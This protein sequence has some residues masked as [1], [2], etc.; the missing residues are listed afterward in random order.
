MKIKYK[1][2][3]SVVTQSLAIVLFLS[4][5][6]N[7]IATNEA[8]IALEKVAKNQLISLRETT[9]VNIESYFNTIRNQVITFSN[10]R[11]IIDA[12]AQFKSAYPRYQDQVDRSGLENARNKLS[13]YYQK[14]FNREFQNQNNEKSPT[15]NEWLTQL[16]D[17]SILLQ[18]AFISSN[19][20]KLGEKDKLAQ[21]GGNSDYG[22]LHEKY[23]QHIRDFQVRFGFYDI[24]LVEPDSGHIVYSV[25]KE[26]DFAT[27]LQTGAFAKTGIG[28]AFQKANLLKDAADTAITDFAPY[29]PS[30]M[31]AASFIASP[32]YDQGHK[33]GI[34][35]FQMPIDRISSVMTHNNQWQEAGLG[36]SGET[37]LVGADR[38]ARTI[39]R[40]LIED[41][42]N[43]FTALQS[44]GVSKLSLN[45][46]RAKNSNI[47]IQR[48]DTFGV[49]EALSGRRGFKVFPDYRNIP[50]LSAYAPVN[51][52]GLN[53]VI[54]AE[55]DEVEAYQSITKLSTAITS[56]SLLVGILALLLGSLVSW[57]LANYIG[58]L[59]SRMSDAMKELAVGDGDLTQRLD[60]STGDELSEI[61]GWFNQFV[62]KLQQMIAKLSQVTV[63][64]NE[65]SKE[66]S[67]NATESL[68]SVSGQQ[69]ETEQLATAMN[70]MQATL[71]E[72]S[73][74]VVAAAMA[75]K[76]ITEE[77]SAAKLATQENLQ[78]STNLAN[79]ISETSEVI[80]KLEQDSDA[81]GSVLDVIKQIADQTNLLALN[82]AIEAARAGEQGRGFAVVADEVRTLASRTQ[83]STQEI[84]LMIESLQ[85]AAKNS[86]HSMLKSTDQAHESEELSNKI[87]EILN[88]ID[89]SISK[90]ND[91]T[92]QI[93]TASE[94]QA[95]VAE[96]INRNVNQI[97]DLS[98]HSVEK[99]HETSETAAQ[100]N[101]LSTQI[102]ELVN[103][104]K[105]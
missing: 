23:H 18:D 65:F 52:H 85:L 91:M 30:Y 27:S 99:I 10:D 19:S 70:E 64:L 43:Y 56:S 28:E 50:V 58:K 75:T 8:Q 17:N 29:P 89:H 101:S 21:V 93:A 13:N 102:T 2:I 16:D 92:T 69:S 83:S 33:V 45:N 20:H 80:T 72:V 25:F 57:L 55:I 71:N 68:Q 94:E 84:Q 96:D 78:A 15:S 49:S 41:P 76:D 105:I 46:I 90:I 95:T 48:I 12:M 26:L 39:S 9:R 3:L 66:Q 1:L 51:I 35:I 31:N 37:Y 42:S 67:A 4:I 98:G 88:V 53:W 36:L 44:N 40:F 32:I 59:L 34:L 7:W 11:M 6:L 81:I 73:R 103:Q 22:R 82:A 60:D 74:N 54:L 24:F 38:K 86:S 104:F 100:I 62:I 79:S 87:F 63:N 77:S 61:A 14:E 5:T 47:G 97:N